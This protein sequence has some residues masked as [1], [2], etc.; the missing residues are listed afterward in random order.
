MHPALRIFEELSA[1]P[2]GSG[3]ETAISEFLRKYAEA[4]G[5]AVMQDEA[6][7][8][9][10]R[11]P[12]SEGCEN[13][14]TVILQGHMDM[15]CE[16]RKDSVHCFETNP[17]TL[18]REGD[19][20]RADG[21][22]LGADDGFALAYGL[23]LLE[24]NAAHP[25]LELVFTV[26]EETTMKGARSLDSSLLAGRILINLD[27]QMEGVITVS[28]AGG[29][30]VEYFLPIQY[31]SATGNAWEL[32]VGGLAGGHSG[33]EIHQ[34][35]G[36]ANQLLC[37]VLRAMAKET[38]LAVAEING[39]SKSNAI[40]VWAA[41]TVALGDPAKAAEL[42][43]GWNRILRGEYRDSD[44]GVEVTLTPTVGR[45]ERVFSADILRR[46]LGA[47][48]LTPTG[49]DQRN[50]GLDLVLSS[51]NISI[52][53]TENERVVIRNFPRSSVSSLMEKM[54][55]RMTLVA[56]TFGLEISRSG[57]YPGWNYRE[58]SPLRCI[59]IEGWEKLTG[60][61][62]RVVGIHAGLEVGFFDHALPGLD[63]ISIAP[64]T[65]G[66]HTP[67]ERMSIS[68]F[69]RVYEYLL[70]LL[71]ELAKLQSTGGRQL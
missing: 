38:P 66:I 43:V 18:I 39:G 20:L 68:S 57:D 5:F 71:E 27:S 32:R 40:P 25:P 31:E 35:R 33:V 12:A 24:E 30:G 49:P 51:N 46:L 42:A 60:K 50:P 56:D 7:N 58:D 4:R 52:V 14:P 19:I 13:A 2:R 61:P 26:E 44:P 64:D 3:N 37:R 70:G 10:V 62:P 48:L 1:I 53:R 67:A 21:T 65:W 59:A 69:L 63:A 54:V 36:N 55:D 11:V 8:V 16:K 15:V 47:V 41:A 9:V 22:T 34:E 23:A 29:A 17:L 45:V 6:M 28:S